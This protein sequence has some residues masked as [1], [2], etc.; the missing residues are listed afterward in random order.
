MVVGMFIVMVYIVSVR[1]VMAVVVTR[2]GMA[3]RVIR[4]VTATVVVV[5]EC[6]GVGGHDDGGYKN[7]SCGDCSRKS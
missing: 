6:P 2:I 3:V 4:I 7:G 1:T 5:V